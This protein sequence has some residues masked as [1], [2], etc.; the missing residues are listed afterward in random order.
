MLLR[1]ALL[2]S[3][4]MT[5]IPFM[6]VC[7][8]ACMCVCVYTYIYTHHIF[9]I[10]SSINGAFMLFIYL[11]YCENSASVNTGVRVSFEL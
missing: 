2:C 11:S 8:Y 1:M 10:H 4:F 3:L 5:N 9:F 7:V 6:C